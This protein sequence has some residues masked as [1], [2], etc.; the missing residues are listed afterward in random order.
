MHNKAKNIETTPGSRVVLDEAFIER[1][2][3]QR[4]WADLRLNP[5]GTANSCTQNYF[6][7]KSYALL[8]LR[9]VSISAKN[10]ASKFGVRMSQTRIIGTR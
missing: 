6:A 2:A 8:D 5:I 3:E 7:I 1:D 9:A 10:I 4:R